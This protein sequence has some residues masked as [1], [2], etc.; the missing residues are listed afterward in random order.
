MANSDVAGIWKDVGQCIMAGD[1]YWQPLR[2]QS[3]GPTL[4]SD[5]SRVRRLKYLREVT[6]YMGQFRR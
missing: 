1:N 4:E 2:K 6:N 5:T 3:S